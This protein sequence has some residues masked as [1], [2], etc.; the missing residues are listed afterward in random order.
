MR[1]PS[2][3]NVIGL[4]TSL[5]SNC[6]VPPSTGARYNEA[7]ET[8]P[9]LVR[10]SIVKCSKGKCR[11]RCSNEYTPKAAAASTTSTMTAVNPAPS[12]FCF[13]AWTITEPLDFT[14]DGVTSCGVGA[15][16]R[17]IHRIGY[18]NNPTPAPR[19]PNNQKTRMVVGSS[20][21]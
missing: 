20:P 2:G 21:E 3:E 18:K 15:S 13:A 16:G 4:S 11:L 19:N 8:L 17:A 1:C 6:G 9:L 12:L 5:V 14:G 7:R 10:L